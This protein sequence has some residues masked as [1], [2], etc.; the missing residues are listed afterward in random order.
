MRESKG[1]ISRR[2]IVRHRVGGRQGFVLRVV[3][4]VLVVLAMTVVVLV[5]GFHFLLELL[6]L[7]IV[8]L[9]ISLLIGH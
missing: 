3:V 9:R 4:V 7:K 5:L 8:I 2:R 6:K 1:Q